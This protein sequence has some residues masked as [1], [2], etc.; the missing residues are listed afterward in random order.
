MEPVKVEILFKNGNVRK[1]HTLD[2]NPTSPTFHLSE[3]I[4]I[5]S[6]NQSILLEMKDIKA[7]LFVKTFEGNKEY[8]ERK[9]FIES[10]RV[11]GRRVEVTF[12]D[13][14]V[15]RGSTVGYDPKR[16]GF[17]LIPVDPGSNNIR[18]FVI[19]DAL[20]TFRFL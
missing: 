8:I 20:M 16:L 2:F 3:N 15:V 10:D 13:G 9:E 6:H 18:I 19:S 17:F 12:A 14:E 5:S 1:G 4:N 11:Q 7:V